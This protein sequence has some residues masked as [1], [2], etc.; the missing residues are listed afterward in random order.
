MTNKQKLNTLS[1]KVKK[2]IIDEV[3]KRIKKE[4]E[5]CKGVPSS[6]LLTI[7]KKKATIPEK[8]ADGLASKRR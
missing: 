8:F 1:V 6:I 2:Q 3:K 5:N 7:L 4:K